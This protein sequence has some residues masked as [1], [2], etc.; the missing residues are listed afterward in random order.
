VTEHIRITGN[1]RSALRQLVEAI[2]RLTHEFDAEAVGRIADYV[3]AHGTDSDGDS[4]DDA[5]VMVCLRAIVDARARSSMRA[6]PP[7]P[8][9]PPGEPS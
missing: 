5:L 4:L 1:E 7:S 9:P 6:A 2:E 3:G 8:L